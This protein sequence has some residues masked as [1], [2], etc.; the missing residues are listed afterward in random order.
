[1]AVPWMVGL[2]FVVATCFA[3]YRRRSTRDVSVRARWTFA[4]IALVLVGV[5]VSFAVAAVYQSFAGAC[6]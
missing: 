3:L 6:V 2:L 1:M 4:T 5:I